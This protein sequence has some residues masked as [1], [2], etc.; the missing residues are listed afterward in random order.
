MGVVVCPQ[1]FM[2][3]QKTAYMLKHLPSSR[4]TYFLLLNEKIMKIKDDITKSK[5]I[6]SES[7]RK[8]K[9]NSAPS[10]V[11]CF[12]KG[13]MR[14]DSRF[15]SSIGPPYSLCV[16]QVCSSLPGSYTNTPP[17]LA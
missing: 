3:S 13:I 6:G 10:R 15:I 5:E 17:H 9:V 2:F 11:I 12:G 14:K 8:G 7:I 4:S 16:V 1:L